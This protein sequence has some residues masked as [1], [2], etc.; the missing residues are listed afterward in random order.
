MSQLNIQLFSQ[1]HVTLEQ[2]VIVTFDSDKGR[3]LLAY[4]AV[5]ADRVHSR[6]RLA[7]LFWPDYPEESARTNL[8]QTLRQLRLAIHDEDATPAFL[9]ITRQTLQCNPDAAITV[10]VLTF[11]RLLRDVA[12][13]AHPALT[14][15]AVCQHHLQVAVALY[16]GDFLAGLTIQESIGF[17][18]WRRIKQEELH[19]QAI[20]ALQQLVTRYE[21]Q[22]DDEQAQTY[23]ARLL[24]IE[25]WYEEAH[26]QL[27]RSL[28]RS[29]QRS[30]ALAQYQRCRQILAD[31]L[32]VAPETATTALYEQIQTGAF[33]PRAVR[34]KAWLTA[35]HEVAKKKPREAQQAVAKSPLAAP[36]PGTASQR[37]EPTIV[38]SPS[39]PRQPLPMPLTP[40]VARAVDLQFIFQRLQEPTVRLLTL[41]G[42][43]G[44]GKTRLALEIGRRLVEGVQT[45]DMR[46]ADGLRARLDFPDGVFF[47]ELASLRSASEIAPAITS[48]L[49]IH[50]YGQDPKQALL[51]ALRDKMVLLILDNFEHLPEGSS[52]VVELLQAAPTLRILATARA[53]LNVH[54]EYLYPVQGMPYPTT[55]TL[56]TAGDAAAVRLFVQSAQQVQPSF[57]VHAENLAAVLR[58]CHL[59]QGMPLGLELAATWTDILPL[60]TIGQEIEQNLDFLST[61]WHNIPERQ[62]SLRA[63]FQWSWQMLNAEEQQAFRRLAIFRGGFT[64][65]AAETITG[66]SL[67]VLTNFVHKSLLTNKLGEERY[68]FHQLLHQFAAEQLDAHPAERLITATRH[69]QFYLEFL[70]ARE[71]QLVGA[72]LRNATDEIHSEIDNIR[73]AWLWAI[74]QADSFALDRSALALSRFYDLTGLLAERIEVLRRAVVQ[75]QQAVTAT[76]AAPT[77]MQQQH[78]SKLLALCAGSLVTQGQFMDGLA[79]AQEAVTMGQ[80]SG[81]VEGEAYGRLIWGQTFYRRGQYPEARQLFMQALAFVQQHESH[82]PTCPLLYDTEHNCLVWLGALESEIGAY[83]RASAHF[84]GALQRCRALGR[85]R[86]EAHV[87][88]NQAVLAWHQHDYATAHQA[89]EETLVMVRQL[90]DHFREGI[91]YL[92]YGEVVRMQGE[93]TSSYRLLRQAQAQLAASGSIVEQGYTFAALG[94]LCGYL[95]DFVSAQQWLTKFFTTPALVE[96]PAVKIEGLLPRTVLALLVG[97]LETAQRLAQE[98]NQVAQA[99]GSRAKQAQAL[100]FLGHAHHAL[101]QPAEAIIAYQ[102]AIT[103]Y[104]QIDDAQSAAEAQ[105]GLAEVTQGQGE[106]AQALALVETLL[107]GLIAGVQVGIDEP[108]Y[109]YLVC[110]QVLA[111]HDDERATAVLQQG[112]ALLTAY[113]NQIMDPALRHSFLRNVPVHRALQQAYRRGCCTS[114]TLTRE[115]H[116][117]E[118]R[119]PKGQPETANHAVY[120]IGDAGMLH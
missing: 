19:L 27:M 99:L 50:L 57:I 64:R 56:A 109:T 84:T 76:R 74:E 63:V 59:V 52:L 42:A 49:G 75:L 117:E 8:R 71:Q 43:G 101:Q 85:L 103:L 73:Q 97:D 106:G 53:R 21:Q 29:G 34:T 61:A 7:A 44:M 82:K 102:Q 79:F 18:E 90:G 1:F 37:A 86:A 118:C 24:A 54:G 62:R 38:S 45:A 70:T 22:G 98:G 78:L 4:L 66:A 94:H 113:A 111:D 91:V 39:L 3:A 83:E 12:S 95:G 33:A 96:A 35:K 32:G 31:E 48:G 119:W 25:P 107:P 93:Y 28:A 89:C 104:A 100:T 87:R 26:R 108:F 17:E 41:V 9:T 16:R 20:Q 105:A 10:D 11:Q 6:S 115:L 65:Q 92:E 46:T 67:R 80:A 81:G 110:Y 51:H 36:P 23:A 114:P 58:I 68:E 47:I 72:N 112:Y 13:H 2:Q 14:S 55:A 120:V 40:F 69:Q 60:A 77:S 116:A 15:C 88:I 30:A 5:E